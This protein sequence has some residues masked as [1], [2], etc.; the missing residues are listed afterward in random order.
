MVAAWLSHV[1]W[2][3][4]GAGAKVWLTYYLI[5]MFRLSARLRPVSSRLASTLA[6]V[7]SSN[8]K[9][10][11]SSL[12]ALSAAQALKSPVTALI[13]GSK[14]DEAI[15]E[16]RKVSG[17]EK[18]ISVKNAEFDHYI[19][20][21]LAALLAETVKKHG[22]STLLAASSA[23]GKDVL[24][25]VSGL[26]DIQPVTDIVK[27][28]SESEFVRPIYAGNALETIKSEQPV[29]ILTVRASAYPQAEP[30]STEAELVE[31]QFAGFS[32]P[33]CDFV[34]EQLLSSKMP[35]LGSATVVVAGGNGLQ[36]KENF[37]ALI[38][39]LAEKLGA[40]VGA[41]RKA[42]D[43]GFCDNSLQIGQTGKVVAPDLYIAV[44]VSGAIQHIAGMKDS[45]VIVAIDSN[46]EAPIFQIADIGLKADL[47]KAV[48]EL[49]ASV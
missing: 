15:A 43:E 2:E 34:S 32:S 24:P 46:P 42:V 31:E 1:S 8:G 6:F 3:V 38:Y 7:E 27:I 44:G 9:I 5:N 36:S 30:A 49:T 40:A 4:V 33:K 41:S 12:S 37:D 29:N 21:P 28:H 39:P 11:P 26:L 13:A 23:T 16:L 17:V 48:P 25:R 10:T 18:V 19:S 45:K 47:M 14:T 22:F 20:E 35:D